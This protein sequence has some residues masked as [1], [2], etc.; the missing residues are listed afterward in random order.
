MI[1][2]IE[3]IYS[4]CNGESQEDIFAKHFGKSQIRNFVHTDNNFENAYDHWNYYHFK[5]KSSADENIDKKK[6]NQGLSDQNNSEKG[7]TV[8]K[9]CSDEHGQMNIMKRNLIGIYIP[10]NKNIHSVDINY[11]YIFKNLNNSFK[12]KLFFEL[13]FILPNSIFFLSFVEIFKELIYYEKVIAY[14]KREN[15]NRK[16][17]LQK[18]TK[19]NLL[20]KIYRNKKYDLKKELRKNFER[21][22]LQK[23]YTKIIYEDAAEL[24]S[25]F[26]NFLKINSH[27]FID[28]HHLYQYVISLYE[29]KLLKHNIFTAI[30]I[31]FPDIFSNSLVCEYENV[32]STQGDVD[33]RGDKPP[34]KKRIDQLLCKNKIDIPWNENYAG[35]LKNE[36]TPSESRKGKLSKGGGKFKVFYK[37]KKNIISIYSNTDDNNELFN[38]EKHLIHIL[39]IFPCTYKLLVKYR[40]VEGYNICYKMNKCIDKY[41]LLNIF[42][43]NLINRKNAKLCCSVRT[44][45]RKEIISS[46]FDTSS[47]NMNS[48]ILLNSVCSK[49]DMNEEIIYNHHLVVGKNIYA[50]I[51]EINRCTK[52]IVFRFNL[53]SKNIMFRNIITHRVKSIFG[54]NNRNVCKY[55]R[56]LKNIN[57]GLFSHNSKVQISRSKKLYNYKNNMLIG[58]LH[59]KE[60]NFHYF[61]DKNVGDIVLCSIC[62][63]SMCG[64]YIYLQRFDKTN[65]IFHFRKEKY[66]NLEKNFDYDDI[67]K[68]D[69][70]VIMELF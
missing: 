52:N 55:N 60:N 41:N 51:H 56:L 12:G 43:V 6:V 30:P 32:E 11:F 18:K 50:Y 7:D 40:D 37:R 25:F 24:C 23:K 8:F 21:I 2:Y 44:N 45:K 46:E 70:S 9:F 27:N 47:Y 15:K 17:N 29:V 58:L 53:N 10:Q 31:L 54:E 19:N 22:L 34:G 59:D 16:F 61:D 68:L 65:L 14:T 36:K 1:R 38:F 4:N 28:L 62:D 5:D 42:K 20:N 39:Y 64:K 33:A 3:N 66:I 63:I 67:T 35:T 26:R 13:Y 49:L 48:N 57:K 69:K